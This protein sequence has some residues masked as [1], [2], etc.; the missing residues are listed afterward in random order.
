MLSPNSANRTLPLTPTLLA[1]GFFLTLLAYRLL[2]L[3]PPEQRAAAWPPLLVG[4][5]ALGL[6]AAGWLGMA[7]PA[8]F[9]RLTGRLRAIFSLQPGQIALLGLSFF[10]AWVA[11]Q[12]A[13]DDFIARDGQMAAAAWLLAAAAVVLGSLRL[14]ER[15]V[16]QVPGWK[17]WETAAVAALFALALLLRLAFLE[18]FPPVLT[19]DEGS[20]GL[21]SVKFIQDGADNL[22]TLGWFSFSTFYFW[23]QS[24]GLR[25]FGQTT[26]GLRFLSAM[27][28][29]LTVP[30]LYGLVR[31]LYG[32]RT[33]LAA[34]ALLTAAHF[35][36]HF[37]RI[38][39]NN[40][41]DG[42]FALL[43]LSFLWRG[44][45]RGDRLWFVLCG[46]V[47]GLSQYFYVSM[48]IF[49]L[50]I[51]LWAGAAFFFDRRRLRRRLP[52]LV[53][54]GLV[55]LVIFLP[56]ALYY[57]NHPDQFNAPMQ[58]VSIFNGWLEREVEL[59]GSTPLAVWLDQLR[60]AALGITT[61]DLR[62]WYAPGAPLLL[63]LTAVPFAM[64]LFW[65]LW[66]PDLRGLLL[67]IPL[68]GIVLMSSFSQDLPSAQRYII[69]SPLALILAARPLAAVSRRIADRAAGRWLL[70]G[71]LALLM[72]IDVQ[73]YFR[74]ATE[75]FDLGG[76]N[77]EV[78][79]VAAY[80]LQPYDSPNLQ[81]YFVGAPR[82]SYR[83]HSTLPFLVPQAQGADFLEP[84]EGPPALV[85]SGP[86]VF[87]FLPERLLELDYVKQAFPGGTTQTIFSRRQE[88]LFVTYLVGLPPRD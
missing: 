12:A 23:I 11:R 75:A 63:P 34:A 14:G 10:F 43:A 24:W 42:L 61:V 84:L 45:R 58:R 48:R 18:A 73:F 2:G 44:W 7:P 22:L 62:H 60:L 47:L 32:R 40:I 50:A 20:A 35:H 81:V 67:L 66:A 88:L 30:A 57:V 27:A 71:A 21:E 17:R 29:A 54:T 56:L 87:I 28:G 6:G 38:G 55:S 4:V 51:L 19:G 70:G 72:A 53:L 65:S 25:L 69:V 13:G 36:I 80:Y 77:T 33:A 3:L 49:P 1:A 15:P 76:I 59:R 31:Q 5:A 41:W 78:A 52:D 64:G 39:L 86:A 37:S 16:P 74:T 9:D 26:T 46:F 8:G 82:M 83:S 79:T 68:A 85:L